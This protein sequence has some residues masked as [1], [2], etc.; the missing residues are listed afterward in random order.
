MEKV[1]H[2][3]AEEQKIRRLHV[4]SSGETGEMESRHNP[5][6]LQEQSEENQMQPRRRRTQCPPWDRTRDLGAPEADE[7]TSQSQPGG[8]VEL[9]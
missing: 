5:G 6:T 8:H 9:C 7:G 4:Q 1:Q 3:E 2:N